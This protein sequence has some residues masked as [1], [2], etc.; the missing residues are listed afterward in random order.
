MTDD[1]IGT[2]RRAM[3]RHRA[4]RALREIAMW[5]SYTMAMLC[6]L[7]AAISCGDSDYPIKV[8]VFLLNLLNRTGIN[9]APTAIGIKERIPITATFAGSPKIHWA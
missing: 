1:I 3:R 2:R 6:F 8:I 5:T 4:K 9:T 7:G